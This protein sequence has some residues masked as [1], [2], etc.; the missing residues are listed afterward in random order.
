MVQQAIKHAG[1]AHLPI[2][3][4]F[5][6]Y[7]NL[8]YAAIFNLIIDKRVDTKAVL[9]STHNLCLMQKYEQY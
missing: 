6:I 7:Q 8:D 9:T 1:K 4:I 3:L 5:I 2:I